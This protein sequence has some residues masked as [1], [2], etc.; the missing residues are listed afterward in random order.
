[1]KKTD[2]T[3]ELEGNK[4]LNKLKRKEF[5]KQKKDQ[6]RREKVAVQLSAGLENFS[7]TTSPN[8]GDKD[9]SFEKDFDMK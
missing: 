3:M 4:S 1:M 6:R 9:Y 8:K 7:L 2:P 5:K